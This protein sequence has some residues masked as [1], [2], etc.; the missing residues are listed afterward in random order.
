MTR[1]ASSSA[2]PPLARAPQP[3]CPMAALAATGGTRRT[4]ERKAP[5]GA[6]LATSSRISRRCQTKCRMNTSL[7]APS[8]LEPL[9]LSN[10]RLAGSFY[11]ER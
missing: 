3:R 1:P 7:K 4:M 6:K 8:G 10:R 2:R 9:Y 5:G 11:M